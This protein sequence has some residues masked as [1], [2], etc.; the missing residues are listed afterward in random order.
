MSIAASEIIPVETWE[1]ERQRVVFLLEQ[2]ADLLAYLDDT[3]K[4]LRA[5]QRAEFIECEITAEGQEALRAYQEKARRKG[6]EQEKLT[7]V[8]MI[9]RERQRQIEEEHW[10]PEHDDEHTDQSL[11]M[12]AVYYAAPE[13][14]HLVQVDPNTGRTYPVWPYSWSR[15]WAKK[16]VTGRIEQL[17]K[18]AALCAAEID[19]LKRAEARE[20]AALVLVAGK[21]EKGQAASVFMMDS[22]VEHL[23]KQ[24]LVE[25]KPD[26]LW[27]T[28]AGRE[29]L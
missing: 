18:A 11:A 12:V 23:V 1:Q 7:G 14:V 6:M 8:E 22:N 21:N 9:A 25:M 5:W 10:T 4:L 29:R 28:D 15:L 3:K 17:A 20:Q 27:I 2:Q 13:G 26:G 16:G 24:G 19:R